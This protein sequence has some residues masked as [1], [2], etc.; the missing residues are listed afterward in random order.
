MDEPTLTAALEREHHEI[1]AGLEAFA[2]GQEAGQPQPEQLARAAAALR[3]HIYLEEE[4]LFP[5]LRAAGLMGPVL[6]ML[7]EHGEIWRTLDELEQAAARSGGGATDRC[8]ELLG[9]LER[10]NAKEEPIVYPEG[11]AKLDD[12]TKQR[13]HGFIEDGT[14][15]EGWVCAMAA[16]RG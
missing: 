6:V 7:R 13:L 4:F 1:D 12:A 8:R 2:A 9:Q 5:P 16:P 15:P 10:H 11:D 3:R 14:M